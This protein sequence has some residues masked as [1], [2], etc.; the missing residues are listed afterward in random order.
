MAF[1]KKLVLSIS[2]LTIVNVASAGYDPVTGRFHQQDPLGRGPRIVHTSNGPKWVGTNGPQVSSPQMVRRRRNTGLINPT[3]NRVISV[4]NP[5]QLTTGSQVSQE[6]HAIPENQYADG[7]NLYEYVKS[8]P[9]NYV[10]PFGLKTCGIGV[11]QKDITFESS[12]EW[13]FFI[14][15]VGHRWLEFPG[16]SMGFYPTGN[17]WFSLGVIERPDSYEGTGK[18]LYKPRKKEYF[19]K[20]K[21]GSAAGKKCKCA[22]CKDIVSCLKGSGYYYT[23]APWYKYYMLAG[24][25]CRHF[26][27]Y[28]VGSC[29]LKR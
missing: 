10:D 8:N 17:P 13:P 22:T 2:V 16:G 25:N 5:S 4:H 29:C 26:V 7:M 11:F 1:L 27:G 20:L 3:P 15:N 9:I 23:S 28:A 24:N 12:D 19:G 14:I 18:L 21:F 6:Q